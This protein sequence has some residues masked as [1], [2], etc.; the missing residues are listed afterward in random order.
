MRTRKPAFVAAAL[1]A[2]LFA[3]SSVAL[4][5]D[6]AASPGSRDEKPWT[7]TKG[8]GAGILALAGVPTAIY[9][10]VCTGGMLMGAPGW[11]RST[12]SSNLGRSTGWFGLA[13]CGSVFVGGAL[14]S[15]GAYGLGRSALSDS[16]AKEPTARELQNEK[17]AL[18]AKRAKSAR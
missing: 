8:V 11:I 17:F 18:P 7:S 13:L 10:A 15:A 14:L 4:A 16:K 1:I 12:S 2:A 5:D 9:G 6:A 3:Q